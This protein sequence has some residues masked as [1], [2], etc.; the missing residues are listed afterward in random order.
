VLEW[1]KTRG[2]GYQTEINKVLRGHVLRRTSTARSKARTGEPCP[3]SGVWVV[4]GEPSTS[5][6]ISK[7]DRMPAVAR[8]RVIWVRRKVA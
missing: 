8:K 2:A 1:F 7:G 5:I 4:D 6:A 3:E